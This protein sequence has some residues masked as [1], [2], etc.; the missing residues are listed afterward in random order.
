MELDE[1]RSEKRV[2]RMKVWVDAQSKELLAHH[3]GKHFSFD[4]DMGLA[5][6]QERVLWWIG[7]CSFNI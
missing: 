2:E 3:D 5:V 6:T 4:I 7:N 1:K